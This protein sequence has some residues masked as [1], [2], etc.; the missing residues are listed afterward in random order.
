MVQ[1]RR[2]TL[3]LAGGVLVS[4]LAGCATTSEGNG[5]TDNSTDT[6]I[7]GQSPS[8]SPTATSTSTSTTT[9]G[10]T[11]S[12]RSPVTS[13][14]RKEDGTREWKVPLDFESSKEPFVT[15]VV[16]D[17]QA[18]PR[19]VHPHYVVT[20]NQRDGEQEITM[21]VQD[22]H[23]TEPVIHETLQF[24]AQGIAQIQIAAPST[25]E[26]A[27][28]TS[29]EPTKFSVPQSTFDC[30]DSAT[31]VYVHSDGEIKHTYI[32]TEMACGTD[33]EY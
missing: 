8:P 11:Q 20:E 23:S 27:I 3:R 29:G 1:S 5:S 25:Y 12:P 24:P 21:R 28:T 13:A 17:P 30:N 15:F 22:R 7:T 6:P 14:T 2:S 26:V 31:G 9:S 16:G 33:T 32:T 10:P 19:D 4:A 18:L